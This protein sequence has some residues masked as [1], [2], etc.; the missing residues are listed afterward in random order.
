MRKII[1]IRNVISTILS[2]SIFLLTKNITFAEMSDPRIRFEDYILNN[3]LQVG[4]E[5]VSGYSQIYFVYEDNKVFISEENINSFMPESKGRFITYVSEI[6]GSNQVFLYDV[7]SKTRLQLSILSTNSNS[8]VSKNGWVVWEG[9]IPEEDTWQVFLF[10]GQDVKRLTKGDLSLNADTDGKYV[11]YSR[12]SSNG[13]WKN[14]VYSKEKDKHVDVYFG[15]NSRSTK[16]VD[17]H[18]V[19]TDG[20]VFDLTAEDVMTLDLNPFLYEENKNQNET[21]TKRDSTIKETENNLMD[22]E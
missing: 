16:L 2:L 22:V 3:N 19:L 21:E 4:T 1:N 13:T 20:E 9:W 6:A 10:D 8:R 5:V 7:L 11:V 15:D 12:K 17:G 14:V 18:I